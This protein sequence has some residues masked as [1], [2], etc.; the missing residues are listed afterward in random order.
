MVSLEENNVPTRRTSADLPDIVTINVED[1]RDTG[2]SYTEEACL[3][4]GIEGEDEYE[5]IV[6]YEEVGE[7]LTRVMVGEAYVASR[8]MC[9]GTECDKL[10]E[11][12]GGEGATLAD[13]RVRAEVAK[14]VLVCRS[15][16]RDIERTLGS[17]S[18]PPR[19]RGRE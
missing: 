15:L 5:E 8:V 17:S 12:L 4:D 9:L 3:P 14:R 13:G 6:E 7:E 2:R 10:L 1:A 11:V 19:L 18:V 16:L